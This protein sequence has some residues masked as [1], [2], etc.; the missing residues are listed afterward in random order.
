MSTESVIKHHIQALADGASL[1]VSHIMP[2]HLN[3]F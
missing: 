1:G 2:S 3:E